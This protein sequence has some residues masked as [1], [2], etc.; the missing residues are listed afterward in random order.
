MARQD[1]SGPLTVCMTGGHGEWFVQSFSADGAAEGEALSLN[2]A[3]AG[4]IASHPFTA[5]SQAAALVTGRRSG[6]ALPLLP[7]ARQW[8]ALPAHFLTHRPA[9]IYGRPPDARLPT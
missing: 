8:L 7:D 3:H 9:P 2:P 1:H 5:G 6:T 4:S